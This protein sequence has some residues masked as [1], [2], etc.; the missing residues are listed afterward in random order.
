MPAATAS[1]KQ[2]TTA[3]ILLDAERAGSAHGGRI[4]SAL[5]PDCTGY[6]HGRT[7][8]WPTQE[9]K[10]PF[11]STKLVFRATSM[12]NETIDWLVTAFSYSASFTCECETASDTLSM[13]HRV[14][15]S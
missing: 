2:Y 3:I 10:E 13:S 5:A 7:A 4:V 15:C 14:R 12:R 6:E 8:C 11:S 9:K 1:S